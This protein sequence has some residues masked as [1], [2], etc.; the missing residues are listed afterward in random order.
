MNYVYE[1]L[2]TSTVD[3]S[4]KYIPTEYYLRGY[5]LG[6]GHNPHDVKALGATAFDMLYRYSIA[7]DIITSADIDYLLEESASL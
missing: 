4:D 1:Q 2:P 6:Q 5:L 3:E 7:G